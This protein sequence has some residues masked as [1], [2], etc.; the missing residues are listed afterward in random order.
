MVGRSSGLPPPERSQ[1]GCISPLDA[2]G[3][4]RTAAGRVTFA[5]PDQTDRAST[6]SVETAIAD[7]RAI[8]TAAGRKRPLVPIAWVLIAHSFLSAG[9]LPA[10]IGECV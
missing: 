5:D 10:S 2:Y 1:Y 8:Q 9:P 6:V 7:A 3:S 4:I